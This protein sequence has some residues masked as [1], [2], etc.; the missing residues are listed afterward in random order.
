MTLRY[1]GGK[2]QGSQVSVREVSQNF[3][4]P[5][6]TTAKVMQALSHHGILDSSQGMKGGYRLLRELKDITFLEISS[7]SQGK[8]TSSQSFC[9]NSKGL[10]DLYQTC[11]IVSPIEQLNLKVNQY[12][13]S[14]TLEQLFKSGSKNHHVMENHL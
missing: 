5:F 14:L 6:D 11:N 13:D 7:I 12:L 9:Q 2:E 10:C 8:S 1:M 4:I 3:N